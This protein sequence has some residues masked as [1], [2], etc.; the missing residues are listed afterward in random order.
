[1]KRMKCMI[2]FLL[3]AVIDQRPIKTPEL[4]EEEGE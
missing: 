2:V 3:V 4:I 1:M